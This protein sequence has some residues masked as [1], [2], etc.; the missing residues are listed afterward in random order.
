MFLRLSSSAAFIRL[1]WFFSSFGWSV[2]SSSSSL[3]LHDVNDFLSGPVVER[4]RSSVLMVWQRLLL[5]ERFNTSCKGRLE[6]ALLLP[7]GGFCL[8][9]A[10]EDKQGAAEERMKQIQTHP[11][12]F[13]FWFWFCHKLQLKDK[14]R[15]WAAEQQTS[16]RFL[17][18]LLMELFILN[19]TFRNTTNILSSSAVWMHLEVQVLQRWRFCSGLLRSP[20]GLKYVFASFYERT[21]GEND[22]FVSFRTDEPD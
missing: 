5:W 9:D 20:V 21:V 7:T 19:Q 12:R 10:V 4:L 1:F 11:D 18:H 13:R 3:R 6:H 8:R 15:G 16:E 2:Y 17:R 22:P 14:N